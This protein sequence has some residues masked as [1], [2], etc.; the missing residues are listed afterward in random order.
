MIGINI[1]NFDLPVV[2]KN[3]IHIIG[4]NMT[5]FA[6]INIQNSENCY[7]IKIINNIS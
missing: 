7:I 4:Q 6:G 1:K 2:Y 5:S 3:N